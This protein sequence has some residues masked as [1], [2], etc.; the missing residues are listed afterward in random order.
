M[1]TDND[2]LKELS[3]M[4]SPL[5]GMSRN[6]PYRLPAGY[7]D[8]LATQV[9]TALNTPDIAMPAAGTKSMPF[10]LPEG[11]FDQLQT[12]ILQQV[13]QESFADSLPKENMFT[14]PQDYFENLPGHINA[15]IRETENITVKHTR[16]I[17]WKRLRWAAAAVVILGLGIGS[18]KM[19]WPGKTEEAS[20]AK[21]PQTS[22]RA[23]VQQN[24]DEFD[25]ELLENN[26][27]ANIN[28]RSQSGLLNSVDKNDIIQYLDENGWEEPATTN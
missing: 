9:V 23:Y 25:S 21:V 8:R 24:I 19:L 20:L 27:A 11:Y 10:A 28:L 22:I 1:N 3:S 16:V 18:V 12:N 2:I 26:I 5:A 4:D 14:V 7:F 6:M 15:R 17:S 13:Q